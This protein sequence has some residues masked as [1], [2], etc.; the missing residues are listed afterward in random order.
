MVQD[1]SWWFFVSCGL[2]RWSMAWFTFYFICA[3]K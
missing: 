3:G 2:Q 1:L